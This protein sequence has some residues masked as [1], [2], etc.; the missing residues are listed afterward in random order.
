[1]LTAIIILIGSIFS[2]LA[3][4]FGAKVWNGKK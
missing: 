1:M 2:V 3:V 4:G